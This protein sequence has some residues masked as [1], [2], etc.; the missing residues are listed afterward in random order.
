MIR[1]SLDWPR[2]YVRFLRGYRGCGCAR[3]ALWLLFLPQ[4]A[5]DP[6]LEKFL[7]RSPDREA[8][9]DQRGMFRHPGCP[10]PVVVA[11]ENNSEFHEAAGGF[12]PCRGKRR[13]FEPLC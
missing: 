10:L 12:V 3:G 2:W 1:R 8:V 9:P 11:L 6:G 13:T 4:R 7:R 5:D